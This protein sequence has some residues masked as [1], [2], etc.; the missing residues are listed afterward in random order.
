MNT[1][2]TMKFRRM[3]GSAGCAVL[4][5][6]FA[7][8]AYAADGTIPQETVKYGDLNVTSAQG[9]V[10]LYSRIRAAAHDVCRSFDN[11]DLASQKL[12][13]ACVHRAISDAV[14][15]VDQAALNALNNAKNGTAK[16][17]ILASGQTR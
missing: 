5:G 7:L 13:D 15:N 10:A 2:T 4:L 6:S 14:Q 8:A 1:N 12:M 11:R 3:I 9:A 16:P 17:I